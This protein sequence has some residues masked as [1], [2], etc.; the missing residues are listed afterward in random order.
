MRYAVIQNAVVVDVVLWDGETEYV[1]ADTLVLCPDD[2]AIGWTYLAGE[3]A[4]PSTPV[5][6][7][8]APSEIRQLEYQRRADPL[9]FKWQRGEATKAQWLSEIAAIRAE[10]PD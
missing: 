4:P 5:A 2:V 8:P 7:G 9:F 6:P 1:T 3:W 10:Y